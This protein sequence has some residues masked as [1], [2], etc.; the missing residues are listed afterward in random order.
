MFKLNNS[1]KWCTAAAVADV[2]VAAGATVAGLYSLIYRIKQ[3][4]IYVFL[5]WEPLFRFV[6][7]ASPFFRMWTL[8]LNNRAHPY[9]LHTQIL[10]FISSASILFCSFVVFVYFHYELLWL[11]VYHFAMFFQL[12]AFFSFIIIFFFFSST[13]NKKL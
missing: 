3:M 6:L 13:F 9:H 10:L 1:I 12:N 4:S 7:S 8:I 11:M 5:F 2:T